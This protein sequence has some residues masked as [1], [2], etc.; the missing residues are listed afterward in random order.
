MIFCRLLLLQRNS[1]CYPFTHFVPMYAFGPLPHQVGWYDNYV[2]NTYTLKQLQT[3]LN[4][5]LNNDRKCPEHLKCWQYEWQSILE[6]HTPRLLIW[7]KADQISLYLCSVYIGDI[8][9]PCVA[10]DPFPWEIP[11]LPSG[12]DDPENSTIASMHCIAIDQWWWSKHTTY[13][14]CVADTYS[15]T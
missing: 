12:N 10:L 8:D 13:I 3:V 9:T 7:C 11:V 6:V 5:V 1:F 14:P 2:M 4:S 15:Y